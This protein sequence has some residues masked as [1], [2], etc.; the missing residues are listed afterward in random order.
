MTI[1]YLD[2]SALLKRYKSEKGSEVV[3]QLFT[4][5][6]PDEVFV[7]SH[8]SVFEVQSVLARQLKAGL[9][10]PRQY[11]RAV[12][13]FVQDLSSYGFVVLA[14][15]SRLVSE[16]IDLLPRYPL[17]TAD[18]LQFATALRIRR[19]AGDQPF[20]MVSSDKDIEEACIDSQME[21]LNPEIASAVD[22]LEKLRQE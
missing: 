16:A 14:L 18:A 21:V 19:V 13:T 10:K 3:T 4:D 7:T 8:L 9:I 22:Q 6:R 1:Y 20:Y 12:G 17:R 5:K 2:S 11:Q 15:D